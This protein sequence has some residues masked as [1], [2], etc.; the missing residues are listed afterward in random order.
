[1]GGTYRDLSVWR[2]SMDL[3]AAIYQCTRRFPD[4]E[5]FGLVSQMRRAAVSIPSNIAEGK[6]RASDRDAAHFM[7]CARGSICE[8]ETQVEIAEMLGYLS[9]E[10]SQLLRSK[11]S[12]V[13][14]LLNG[15]IKALRPAER[16]Q[17]EALRPQWRKLLPDSQTP[18]PDARRPE[19]EA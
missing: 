18:K 11:M 7:I 17:V 9:R 6:G 13:A 5:R 12:I 2:T 3:V 14:R 4:D 10:E 16:T 8:I 1:M 15:L 19:P